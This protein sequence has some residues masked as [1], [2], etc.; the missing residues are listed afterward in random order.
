[1]LDMYLNR[2][3]RWLTEQQEKFTNV[4]VVYN[5]SASSRTIRATVGKVSQDVV[6]QNMVDVNSA[7][8]D[9]ILETKYLDE[10]PIAGDVIECDGK[11]FEVVNQIDGRCFSIIDS[12]FET[13]RVHTQ[14]VTWETQSEQGS[15]EGE[16]EPPETGDE[17]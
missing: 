5:S 3:F 14:L 7:Y 4:D 11:N 8:F 16:Q 17:P 15:E 6:S 13:V 1:M 2:G 12:T 9:F 10:L